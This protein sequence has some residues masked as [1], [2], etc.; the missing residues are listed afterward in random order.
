MGS[1]L[2]YRVFA[3]LSVDYRRRLWGRFGKMRFMSR[4]QPTLH[5]A[6]RIILLQQPQHTATLQV[7]SDE[8]RRQDLYRKNKGDGLYPVPDQFKLRT[9]HYPEFQFLPPDTVRYVG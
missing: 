6:M 8:N 3:V 7:L 4:Q 5:E 9:F 2:F 1:K